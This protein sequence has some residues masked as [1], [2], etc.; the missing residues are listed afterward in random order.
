MKLIK[1][2]LGLAMNKLVV[3]VLLQQNRLGREALL[4]FN[5]LYNQLGRVFWGLVA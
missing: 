2:K 1:V 4:Y 3:F 5:G